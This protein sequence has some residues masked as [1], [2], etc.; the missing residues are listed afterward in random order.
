LVPVSNL[1]FNL[2]EPPVPVQGLFFEFDKTS[3]LVSGLGCSHFK[4]PYFR[5]LREIL[6]WVSFLNGSGFTYLGT[7]QN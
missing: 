3:N 7:P 6:R 5:F 2:K 4:T 1:F